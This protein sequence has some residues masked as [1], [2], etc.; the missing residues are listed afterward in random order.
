MAYSYTFM[1][2]ARLPL[3]GGGLAADDILPLR[4]AEIVPALGH[5]LPALR[6][7]SDTEGA[8]ELDEGWAEFRIHEDAKLGAWLSMRCSLRSD[9]TP[10]VQ[11]LCDRFGW[12]AFDQEPR[13]FQPHAEPQDC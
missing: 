3:A 2:P 6:W 11:R 8:V 13:L 1:K 5:A 4:A 10:A 12:I 7:T 9:Y